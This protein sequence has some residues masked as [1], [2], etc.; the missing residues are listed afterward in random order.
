MEFLK[1]LPRTAVI[2]PDGEQFSYEDRSGQMF[3]GYRV[4]ISE[5]GSET[6]T[7]N[8]SGELLERAMDKTGKLDR[9]R[10]LHLFPQVRNLLARHAESKKISFSANFKQA[11][12]QYQE[13][14]GKVTKEYKV[15]VSDRKHASK[16]FT[17]ADRTETMN[18]ALAWMERLPEGN[19]ELTQEE[20]R[21]SKRTL[22]SKDHYEGRKNLTNVEVELHLEYLTKVEGWLV[23]PAG[24]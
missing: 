10:A 1:K 18:R 20:K 24:M 9:T 7:C 6:V 12:Y 11:H 16:T 21:E 17:G 2:S 3:S 13:F 22:V 4:D 14:T 5:P 8:V 19:L 15:V 23:L